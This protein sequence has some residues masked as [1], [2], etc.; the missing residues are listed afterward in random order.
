M[1]MVADRT[2]NREDKGFR[3]TGA[4]VLAILVVSFGIVFAVNGL[5]V[6]YALS[7]FRGQTT[8]HPYERGLSYNSEIEAAREQAARGWSLDAHVE[9][10]A[11]GVAHVSVDA[12]DAAG[13]PLEGLAIRAHFSAPADMKLDRETLLVQQA[14]GVFVGEVPLA[15]SHWDLTLVADRD[16]TRLFHSRNRILVR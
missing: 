9:R 13:Q 3:L 14:P 15:A 2:G 6:H 5:M 16:G 7:T 1:S 8:E 10:D 4:K 11:A 12:R